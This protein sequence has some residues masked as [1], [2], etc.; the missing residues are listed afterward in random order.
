MITAN[1][2]FVGHTAP[3]AP[4]AFPTLALLHQRLLDRITYVFHKYPTSTNGHRAVF[5]CILTRQG[6]IDT[7]ALARWTHSIFRAYGIPYVS[8]L[9]SDTGY[10]IGYQLFLLLPQMI[11][12]LSY[13]RQTHCIFHILSTSY[14]NSLL[15]G[16]RHLIECELPSFFP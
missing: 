12:M 5:H 9:L 7:Y 2:A 1:K 16:T 3:F 10:S 8:F 14:E 15:S 6:R 13:H 4:S 11:S